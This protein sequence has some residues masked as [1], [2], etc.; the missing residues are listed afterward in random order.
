MSEV[1]TRTRYVFSGKAIAVQ[2]RFEMVSGRKTADGQTE[3]VQR[4]VGW[5]V[6]LS[7][8]ASLYLGPN[9]P[10]IA[11]GEEVR[12]TIEAMA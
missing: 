9:K 12:I 7:A 6:Q 4:S 11:Q 10:D 2:E 5:F 3:I 1:R 8:G